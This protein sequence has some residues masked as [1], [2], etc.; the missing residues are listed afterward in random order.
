MSLIGKLWAGASDLTFSSGKASD[1]GSGYPWLQ[2]P[3]N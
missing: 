2:V 3:V 1:L